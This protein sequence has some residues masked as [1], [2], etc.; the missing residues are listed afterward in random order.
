MGGS[1]LRCMEGIRMRRHEGRAW[2]LA[3]G[4][5]LAGAV[6]LAVAGLG[7]AWVAGPASAAA[8]S[9]PT[10][11]VVAWG[12]NSA[13]QTNVPADARSGVISAQGG[14]SHSIA[15]RSD[16]RV[17]AWGDNTYGQT[18]VPVEAQSGVVAIVAGC[19]HSIAIKS[20]GTIV[21]WGDN[22]YG[23]SSVPTIPSGWRWTNIAA[24]DAHSVGIARRGSA[25]D[26]YVWGDDTYG[27]RQVTPS[28]S[29]SVLSMDWHG[30]VDVEAGGNATVARMSDGTV[31]AWGDYIVV[32][33]G[34]R[35]PSAI[36]VPAG[37]NKVVGMSVGQQH[38]LVLRSN[39]TVVAW[40][41]NTYGQ[42]NVPRNL[43]GVKAVA[44]G[45][46]HSLV[47]LS[48][49][50]ILGWGDNSLGQASQP[51][52]G[53]GS[54][55]WIGIGYKHSL[56]VGKLP[57]DTPTSVTVTP[58]DGAVT[59][60]WSAPEDPG[61][62]P[63]TSY[64]VTAAPG[65]QTCTTTNTLSCT[66]GGL[67]NGTPYT[68]SVR[69]HNSIGDGPP[70][71]T[72]PTEPA[73]PP[74]VTPTPEPTATPTESP[75]STPAPAAA[76]ASNGG[77]SLPLP[78]LILIAVAIGLGTAVVAY[79][80]SLLVSRA[81]ELVGRLRR[82]SAAAADMSGGSSGGDA[83]AEDWS[84]S[85]SDVWPPKEPTKARLE[86]LS[87][88]VASVREWARGATRQKPRR[89]V[90]AAVGGVIVLLLLA[91]LLLGPS[92]CGSQ[93]GAVSS[94]TAADSALA[95]ESPSWRPS[96]PAPTP[97]PWVTLPPEWWAMGQP[98]TPQILGGAACPYPGGNGPLY[99]AG[100]GIYD[101]RMYVICGQD[102]VAIDLTTNKAVATYKSVFGANPCWED[103]GGHCAG[104]STRIAVTPGFLWASEDPAGDEPAWT[105]RIDL[106]SR[107]V[108]AS[109]AGKITGANLSTV[110]ITEDVDR[111][112]YVTRFVDGESGTLN[113][114]L[115][116]GWSFDSS[117]G[118]FWTFRD[119]SYVRIDSSGKVIWSMAETSGIESAV[120]AGGQCWLT[121]WRDEGEGIETDILRLTAS[122]PETRGTVSA[123]I[124]TVRGVMWVLHKDETGS[125]IISQIDPETGRLVGPL[126]VIPV[127]WDDLLPVQDTLWVVSDGQLRRLDLP[128]TP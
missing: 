39:G 9:L 114:Q 95:A 125:S 123:R 17:V 122:G 120:E 20:N 107:A 74:L 71:V 19:D 110:L 89:A 72:L 34:S 104:N 1:G 14:C 58:W 38:A 127:S 91:G 96:A 75:N 54:F 53:G 79:R 88:T 33:M 4:W 85:D 49:G 42:T 57:P 6:A 12:D 65:G 48:N 117:C 28:D 83:T 60:S 86:P 7:P 99:E 37:L 27:Q 52:R 66:I 23:Q 45:G 126:W 119:D 100:G 47:L 50:Q 69:A 31:F 70:A 108:K 77:G 61:F 36:D 82:G 124:Q 68:F 2:G 15:L 103:T 5:R 10:G 92:S 16:G 24:G 90:A 76:P 29:D 121:I 102:V 11:G 78:L 35:P 30:I 25:V 101:G 22:R 109:Y 13:G 118:S 128:I 73:V 93:P 41:D 56:A 44:A 106:Q 32:A 43:T 80:P 64:T 115:P 84:I 55:S 46:Y 51:P 113:G 40:G 62:S 8:A 111:S 67:E 116:F 94:P 26:V 3:R 81:G 105:K 21:A 97:I 63:I 18:N 59:I 98:S 87:R 112:T